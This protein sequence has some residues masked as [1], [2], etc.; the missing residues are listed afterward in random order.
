LEVL[1]VGPYTLFDEI[2]A[3]GMGSVYFARTAAGDTVAIKRLHPHLR[4]DGEFSTALVDE[5]RLAMSVRHPNVVEVVDVVAT[6]QELLLVMEYVDGLSLSQLAALEPK[7]PFPIAVAIASD[8]LEGLHAAHQAI[9]ED[10]RPL[11]LVHRDVSPQNVLLSSSG[12]AKLT[13]FGVAKARGRL[14][15]TEGDSL[16]G[17]IAYM[18]PEQV[19][20]GSS[21]DGRSDVY[22]AAVV[23]WELFAGCRL[24]DAPNEVALIAKVMRGATAR[25]TNVDPT[26]PAGVDAVVWRALARDPNRR[27]PTALAFRD[28]LAG[29][30]TAADRRAVAAWLAERYVGRPVPRTAPVRSRRGP[31]LALAAGAALSFGIAALVVPRR[32][33]TALAE[34]VATSAVPEPVEMPATPSASAAASAILAGPRPMRPPSNATLAVGPLTAGPPRKHAS[35][36]S[37]AR[38]HER[39][40]VEPSKPDCDP[41][42]TVDSEGV[43][44]FK[45]ACFR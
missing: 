41:P 40:P 12:V 20:G 25:L 30:A 3:G 18:S 37:S 43:T 13:D 9:G 38:R 15:S 19:S 14:R 42:Y 16:K 26:V 28:E 39:P 27:P 6:D 22:A 8:L 23:I 31:V 21:L 32:T 35:P 33:P 29:A 2:A 44:R 1:V 11:G 34:P 24:F 17:K 4:R 36:P 7:I 10:G 45:S 5:A